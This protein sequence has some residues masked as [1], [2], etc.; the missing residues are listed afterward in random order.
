[1]SQ[2]YEEEG[3]DPT[4]ADIQSYFDR[5]RDLFRIR[6]PF[7]RV[8][9]L[10]HA[11][12][13]TA[14]AARRAMIELVRS[15]NPDSVW[16]RVAARFADDATAALNLSATHLPESHLFVNQPELRQAMR[17]LRPGETS[18]VIEHGGQHHVVQV[19]DVAP[20]GSIPE[21]EWV[22]AE[23]R[24]R[25]EVQGR[26]QIYANQVQRLRNEALSRDELEIR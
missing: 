9:H 14:Q 1:L 5:H 16:Q 15:S 20:A 21:I 23:L 25:L 24:R 11:S 7:V 17:S 6:E 2:L 13:D 19:V 26:K 18:P 12:A 10:S 3:A 22:E 8:R 4:P